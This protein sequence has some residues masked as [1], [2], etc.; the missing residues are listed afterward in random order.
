MDLLFEESQDDL[1]ALFFERLIQ[2]KIEISIP[3]IPKEIII[4]ICSLKIFDF[5]ELQKYYACRNIYMCKYVTSKIIKCLALTSKQF[6][7]LFDK[8]YLIYKPEMG[9]RTDYYNTRYYG[10]CII[11]TGEIIE[12]IRFNYGIIYQCTYPKYTHY[13]MGNNDGTGYF[14][15]NN[16]VCLKLFNKQKK[17]IT[18]YIKNIKR[19]GWDGTIY[20]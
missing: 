20:S 15:S 10:Y 17:I 2:L 9:M 3:Y 16:T 4:K 13:L 1:F 6:L 5:S 12:L 18:D 14:C 19:I 8:K 7:F 11:M